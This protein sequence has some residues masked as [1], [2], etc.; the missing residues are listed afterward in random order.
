MEDPLS[1]LFGMGVSA[2][3]AAIL[4]ALKRKGVLTEDEIETALNSAEAELLK[5]G[6]EIAGGAAGI[7]Q[8]IRDQV[9]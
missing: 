7:V 5:H 1:R 4:M 8:A 9:K 6:T 2:A 3:L